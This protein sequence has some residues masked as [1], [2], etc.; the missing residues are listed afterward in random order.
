MK[1]VR[2]ACTYDCPDACGLL[3][4]VEG[5]RLVV[6]G[7]PEHP[8]TRGTVCARGRR[9]PARL[10]DRERLTRPRRR[11]PG[12][13]ED[14]RWDDALD[15]AAAKLG[16]ALD[17]HGAPSVVY[18]RGGGSLGLSKELVSHFFHS[19]GPVTTVQGG[20]CGEAGEAA[21]KLDFGDAASH[22]YTDLAH[23]AAVVLWGKNPVATG[24]HLV[25]F[26]REARDRGA[27]LWLV[28]PRHTE[29]AKLADRVIRV[30][31]G[32]DG[33][34]AL[35]VLEYERFTQTF[36]VEIAA[37]YYGVLQQHDELENELENLR[38]L[39]QT[40][41]FVRSEAEHGMLRPTDV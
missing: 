26:L 9:H 39:E 12:G 31:P 1:I 37:D 3:A 14:I 27:P 5:D 19:L 25:P 4:A 7:D 11:T 28:E 38:R 36:A 20:V 24:R 32:G 23:S 30:A 16:A 10:R 18:V 40:A 15:L 21:Q 8:I 33:F 22:D 41:K 2:T 34:L 6:R 35:A 13:W 17:E 29:T